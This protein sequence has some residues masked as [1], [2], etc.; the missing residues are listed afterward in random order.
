MSMELMETRTTNILKSLPETASTELYNCTENIVNAINDI[1]SNTVKIGY[2]LAQIRDTKSYQSAGYESEIEYAEKVF[3]F[4]KSA[5]YSFMKLSDL[6]LDEKGDFISETYN[7]YT[8]SQLEAMTSLPQHSVD[9]LQ[10]DG[11]ITPNMTVKA[12][13]EVVKEEKDRLKNIGKPTKTKKEKTENQKKSA[14][15][16]DID[17]Y[18]IKLGVNSIGNPYIK[19]VSTNITDGTAT[20]DIITKIKIDGLTEMIAKI[21]KLIDEQSNLLIEKHTAYEEA[22][23]RYKAATSALTEDELQDII[24][25]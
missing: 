5:A 14:E 23:E 15:N 25:S 7:D 22:I 11:K 1:K 3:G 9:R 12:I 16:K 2:N 13:K 20:E 19:L 8:P 4:K 21:N 24:A 6:F 18:T 10:N 17:L